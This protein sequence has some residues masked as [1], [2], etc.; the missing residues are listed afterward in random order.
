MDM[1]IDVHNSACIYMLVKNVTVKK[2]DDDE[3]IWKKAISLV[4]IFT[5]KERAIKIGR[6]ERRAVQ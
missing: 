3:D 1:Y 2:T 4:P 5:S 6:G